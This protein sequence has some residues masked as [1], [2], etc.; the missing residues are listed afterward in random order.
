[1]RTI[2]ISSFV[3]KIFSHNISMCA[4][5]SFLVD[6]QV[7]LVTSFVTFHHVSELQTILAELVR[8]LRVGGYLIIREHDCEN[9]QSLSAKYLNFVHAIMMIAGVGEF[10]DSQHAKND[11]YENWDKQKM[12]I[13][14]YTKSIRYRSCSE[15]NKELNNV[16]FRH[17][18]T[19]RYGA[20]GSENPQ[21][22]FY[23]VYR[24]ETK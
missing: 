16:G 5:H 23:A 10:A 2:L 20:N 13:I 11:D 3:S 22:L 9:K 24:L 4:N 8:I 15:W 21:N 18:A 1:M 6:N 7:D 17:R 19:L 14:E 12:D